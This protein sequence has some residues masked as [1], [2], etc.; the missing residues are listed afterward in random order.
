MRRRPPASSRSRKR[1]TS[2]SPWA[3]SSTR[4]R[5]TRHPASSWRSCAPGRA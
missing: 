2:P 4:T 3:A 5:S 1:P